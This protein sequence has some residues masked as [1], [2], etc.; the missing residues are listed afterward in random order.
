MQRIVMVDDIVHYFLGDIFKGMIDYEE[1]DAY[2]VKLTRDAEYDLNDELDQSLLDKMSK[3]LKQ[4][5]TA[6]PVRLGYD[7]NMPDY[8][9]KYLRKSLKSYSKKSIFHP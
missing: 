5:L 2:S 8:M 4:R 3:G 6:D 9:L 7:K 1:I